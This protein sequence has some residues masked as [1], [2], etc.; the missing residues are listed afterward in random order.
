M[1]RDY[2]KPGNTA[3]GTVHTRPSRELG[4]TWLD[5]VKPA[6]GFVRKPAPTLPSTVRFT[7]PEPTHDATAPMSRRERR[8]LSRKTGVDFPSAFITRDEPL[9]AV[10]NGARKS[11]RIAKANRDRRQTKGQRAFTRQNLAA[12]RE[13][14]TILA[15]VAVAEGRTTATPAAVENAT[16]GL[17]RRMEAIEASEA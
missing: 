16:F 17:Q 4:K 3:P 10:I 7:R 6:A 14:D 12:A 15:L 11:R 1:A 8:E 9:H 5:F 13:R 2:S